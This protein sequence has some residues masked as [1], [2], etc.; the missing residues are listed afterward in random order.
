MFCVFLLSFLKELQ[1]LMSEDVFLLNIFPI[2]EDY[3]S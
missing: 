3:V 2:L 1:S